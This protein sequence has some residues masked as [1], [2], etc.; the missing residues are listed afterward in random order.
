MKRERKDERGG[1]PRIRESSRFAT[2]ARQP[3]EWWSSDVVLRLARFRAYRDDHMFSAQEMLGERS[4]TAATS[5]ATFAS[6]KDGPGEAI[7]ASGR[8]RLLVSAAE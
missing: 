3:R 4:D 6:G 1:L 8:L 5:G 7:R 2:R